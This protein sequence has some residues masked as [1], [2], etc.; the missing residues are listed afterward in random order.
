MLHLKYIAT[1]IIV[2][3]VKQNNYNKNERLPDLVYF[4]CYLVL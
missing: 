1:E 4:Q 3:L 2:D